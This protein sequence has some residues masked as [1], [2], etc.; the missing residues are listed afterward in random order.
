MQELAYSPA[1][2]DRLGGALMPDFDEWIDVAGRKGDDP[3]LRENLGHM[4]RHQD[5]H[6]PGEVVGPALA[7]LPPGHE[8]DVADARQ[9]GDCGAVEQVATQGLDAPRFELV[10]HIGLAEAGDADHALAGSRPL[11]EPGERRPHLAADAE[12]EDVAI[13]RSEIVDQRL[14]RPGHKIFQR[15][16]VRE[17]IG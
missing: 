8:H 9:F 4:C 3:R 11:G 15:V 2:G 14:R 17:C 6:C 16:Y 5:V 12:D 1:G 13:D 10:L 7:K